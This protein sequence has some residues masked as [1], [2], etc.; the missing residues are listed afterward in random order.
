MID[1]DRLPPEVAKMR[2]VDAHVHVFPPRVFAA[3]RRWFDAHAWS[4]RYR[5]EARDTLRFLLDR[6]V[7]R[8][9]GLHYAHVPGMA[10]SLNE[11]VAE[12]A[13][14][15]PRLVPC[16]T[17]LP[18]EPGARAIVDHA[19]GALGCRGIKIHCHVQKLAPDDPRLDDVFDAAAAHDVPLVIH[20]GDAPASPHYGC[21]VKALCTPAALD[22]ALAKHPRTHVVVPHLGAAAIDE[23]AKLLDAHERLWLDTTM[24][25]GGAFDVKSDMEQIGGDGLEAWAERVFAIVRAWPRR[26]L[27]G[28]DFPNVPYEW[29]RELR[30]LAKAGLPEGD[31]EAVVSGNARR[32]FRLD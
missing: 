2:V 4:I 17:V 14:E 16:A 26:V 6:G 23:V 9:V 29:D 7:D 25:L 32:L 18:G 20:A 21:D 19:L 22:R 28:T 30:A 11:F 8:V 1:A 31:L 10:G 3:I 5:L 24:T 13:K 12:L 27:Y 15:E